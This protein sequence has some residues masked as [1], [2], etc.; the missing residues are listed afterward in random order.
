GRDFVAHAGVAKLQMA[1]AAA[2]GVPELEQ[3]PGRAAG[4]GDDR[5]AGFGLLIEGLDQ[6]GLAHR[7]ALM[8]SEDLALEL[9][10][11]RFA[12]GDD[13]LQVGWLGPD[14][15][16]LGRLVQSGE[17]LTSV[18]NDRHGALLVGIVATDVD[19]DK[20]HLRVVEAGL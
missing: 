14:I 1:S 8:M 5:V 9:L 3:V 13:L 18:G 10:S 11:P 4:S 17:R 12:G 7:L 19:T 15:R 16:P 20:A 2:G 6:L